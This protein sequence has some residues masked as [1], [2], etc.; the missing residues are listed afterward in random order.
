[1]YSGALT[2]TWPW[3]TPM[4]MRDLKNIY[5]PLHVHVFLPTYKYTVCMP[6][7]RGGQKREPD[8]SEWELAKSV[9]CHVLGPET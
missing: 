3:I 5:L 7:A 2:A 6:G 9:N 8:P 4:Q 1:M